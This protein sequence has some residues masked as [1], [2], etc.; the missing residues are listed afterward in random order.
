[1]YKLS[2]HTLGPFQAVLEGKPVTD[3]RTRKVQALLILLTTD[4]KVHYREPLL[5]LLWPGLPESSARSNLRQIIYYLRQLF[6]ETLENE[7]PLIITNRH[8]IRLNSQARIEVDTARFE[9]HIDRARSHGHQDIHLCVECLRELEQAASLYRGDF[10]SD[11]YLDD[12]NEFEDWAQTRR[13]YYRYRV[14]DVL[15]VLAA[16]AL[17]KGD[18]FQ[19]QAF[20]LRQ[21]EID[22]LHESAY[23]Q[24]M[25]SLA[26]SGRRAEALAVYETCRRLLAD[27]LGMEPSARTAEIFKKIRVDDLSF[28]SSPVAKVRGYE[29]KEQVGEGY[30]GTIHRAIQTTVGR[31]VAVKVIRRKYTNDPRFIRRFEAEAQTVARLEHPYIVPLYD[32]WRDPDGAYL[33]MRYMRR[34]SLLTA[35]QAGPWPPDQTASMLDQIASALSIAHMQ[36]VVHRDIKP[37]NILLDEAGNAYLSDFGIAQV[38]E[39]SEQLASA[40]ALISTL[41]YISP[42]QILG[43]P[44]TPQTDIYSLGAVLYETLTGQK[45]FSGVTMAEILHS[46]LHDPF[47]QVT[48]SFPDIAMQIDTVLQKATDKNPALRHASTLELAEEFRRAACRVKSEARLRLPEIQ[49]QPT[50]PYKGLLA[51]QEADAANFFGR[52]ALVQQLLERLDGRGNRFLAVVGPSGSGKSSIVKAGLIPKLRQGALPGSDDWYIA[53]MMPGNRP[54]DELER[55]LWHLAVEPPA[56]LIEPMQRDAGGILRTIRRILP[57]APE[58]QLLLVIDQFEELFTLVEAGGERDLFLDG[59][60]AA[61]GAPHSPVRLVVTLRADYYDRPLEY[62]V[63]GQMLKENTEIVLPLNTIELASAIREPARRVGVS[64]EEGLDVSIVAEVADQ[65]GALPL[66]QYAMTEL[67]E[68]CEGRQITRASYTQIGGVQA[69]LNQRAEALYADLDEAGREA[70]RQ[71]F[72]RLVTLG[73]GAEDTRRRVLRS[74]LEALEAIEGQ[75]DGGRLD[76]EGD[77]RSPITQVIDIFGQARLLSFDRDP[78]TRAPTVEVAHEALLREWPRLRAW[79]DESLGEVRLQRALGS[80]AA[81]WD[82][83]GRDSSFLL[84]GTRLMQ[85]EIWAAETTLA[86]SAEERSYLQ[87]SLSGREGRRATEQA[88]QAHEAALERRS[89]NFLRILVVAL[90]LGVIASL[91]MAGTARRAQIMAEDEAQSRATQQA[92]AIVREEAR[93]TQQA[94]AEAEADARAAAEAVALAQ[95]QAAIRQANLATARELSLAAHLNL[96]LD[97]ELSIMLALQSLETAYTSIGEEALRNALHASRVR[98]VVEAPGGFSSLAY[99]PDGARIAALRM[100][101]MLQLLDSHSGAEILSR[102][103][104]RESHRI[105]YSPD[106]ARLVVGFL[107]GSL[108]ILNAITLETN[109]PPLTGHTSWF[110]EVAFSPDGRFLVSASNDGTV[111]IWESLTGEARFTLDAPAGTFNSGNGLAFVP[112]TSHLLISDYEAN[113]RL[114][115]LMTGSEISSAP[116]GVSAG[117]ILNAG[118]ISPD[119]SWIAFTADFGEVADIWELTSLL[120]GQSEQ[121]LF[122]LY[123]HQNAIGSFDFSQDAR[124]LATGSFDSTVKIWALSPEGG[125]ELLTLS[126]H[127]AAVLDAQLSPDGLSL[128][129][130]S[131]D[132]TLRVWDI[133]VQGSRELLT[134]PTDGAIIRSVVFNPHGDRLAA[135][136]FDGKVRLFDAAAGHLLHIMAHPTG[137]VYAVAFS[138]DGTHL[139]SGG[140]DFTVRVWEV[141]SGR[142]LMVL[143][144]HEDIQ[145]YDGTDY[146]VGALFPG[147]LKV[148]YSP[149]GSLIAST[150]E[151]STVRLW[152]STTGVPLR[153]FHIHPHRHGGTNL[154]FSPDGL[155]LAASTEPVGPEQSS[156]RPALVVIWD[157]TSEEQLATIDDLRFRVWGMA[158]SPDGQQLAIGGFGGFLTIRDPATGRRAVLPARAHHYGS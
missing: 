138:P 142:E 83:A 120:E 80:A 47:P 18:H 144:G 122:R 14:L 11:F 50:N 27:E 92:L 71:L 75:G 49:R 45:P 51:F 157:V 143:T 133:S 19:A 114:I 30:S 70:A 24:L 23:R 81:E 112:G 125:Q 79:L 21:I 38:L 88:R 4:Q 127:K 115:D 111:R 64:L 110:N 155:L 116:T 89:R 100:D 8:E 62:Q 9:A 40:N 5:E 74:E 139:V 103:F 36:G 52:E 137:R 59:L 15:A 129:S 72:L 124:L 121:P 119:G 99:S 66:V 56:S 131:S 97:P 13:Q 128:A 135:A 29:L 105:A 136:G 91:G 58:T 31:E 65:P 6:P 7:K 148:S 141:D 67:F 109:L 150:G 77:P 123:G 113:K 101:N 12:S 134:L 33:V 35:L 73:E 53:E 126:G 82:A 102:Q 26:L 146:M 43:E 117:R 130:R 106:G 84:R 60:M 98:F 2:L 90:V 108:L 87:A 151:D 42:E 93:A 118:S 63:L 145:G 149:D 68:R 140:E 86:M 55:A 104:D 156:G 85:F 94:L 153:V 61:I 1:M 32:Y 44:V 154:A 158:F 69:A 34:G 39:W 78:L 28:E 3:F 76:Q 17:R 152:D 37:G 41:D 48:A 57:D 16:D 95:E 54:F 22:P 107:D 46:H 25:K 147:V 20:N 132:G 10:L 96:P